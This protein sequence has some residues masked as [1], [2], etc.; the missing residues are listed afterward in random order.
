MTV[1]AKSRD[2]LFQFI[3]ES[4]FISVLGGLIGIVLGYIDSYGRGQI[5]WMACSNY[6]IFYCPFICIFFC[7]RDI[8]R[9]VSSEKSCKS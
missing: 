5:W 4:I 9:V 8:F 6:R 2:V 7:G 3:I 1:G